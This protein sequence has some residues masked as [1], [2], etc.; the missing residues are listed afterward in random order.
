MAALSERPQAP[1]LRKFDD[2]LVARRRRIEFLHEAFGSL[3]DRLCVEVADI[4]VE[5]K[6]E[7]RLTPTV[8][9]LFKDW[10]EVGYGK[11]GRILILIVKGID[12]SRKAFDAYLTPDA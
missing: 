1:I 3:W 2:N 10:S 9:Q 6:S 8:P 5:E 7:Q 4:T 11:D 12:R